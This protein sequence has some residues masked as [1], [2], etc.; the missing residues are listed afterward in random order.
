[1]REKVL[2]RVE[3]LHE[4]NPMLGLRGVRLSIL[5]PEITRMQVRAIIEAACNLR[6]RKIDA[7]PEIM[8]PLAGTV[9]ELRTVHAALKPVAA[10]VQKEMGVRVPY[11][12]GTMIEI[13]RADMDE[14]EVSRADAS[15]TVGS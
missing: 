4:A 8:I 10:A 9:A 7:R 6:K 15:C 12:F 11:K 2:A 5:Y 1:E 14:L 3:E 13:P